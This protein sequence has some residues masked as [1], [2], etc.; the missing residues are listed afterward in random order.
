MFWS[1]AVI[2]G[3]RDR[4]KCLK[5]CYVVINVDQVELSLP[6]KYVVLTEALRVTLSTLLAKLNN[7]FS[8]IKGKNFSLLLSVFSF[9]PL[10]QVQHY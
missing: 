9:Y 2:D 1:K 4:W 6:L 10:S 3:R 7:Q 5:E 8:Y